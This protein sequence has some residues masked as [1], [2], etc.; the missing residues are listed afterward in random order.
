MKKMIFIHGA[1]GTG[2]VWQYQA[3]RFPGSDNVTL[4]GRPE[5]EP[6]DSID[7]YREWLRGYIA[8]KGYGPPVL[9]GQSMGGGIALSYALA[10]PDETA[11]LILIGSGA[12]LRVNPAFLKTM[13]DNIDKPPSWYRGLAMTMY[14][15]VEERVRESVLDATCSFPVSLHLNDFLCC[16][17][18]DVMERLPELKLPVLV[19]CGDK[20]IMT[21]LKYSRFMAEKITGSRLA[22]I[23]DAGHMA[24]LEKP[25]EVNREIADFMA[26][27]GEK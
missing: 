12:R 26:E 15:G 22:V 4:P 25:D 9:A 6:R 27:I 3:E 5:G 11:A 19:I 13:S 18:F 21:P 1:G 16:D 7:G 23:P 14:G 24:F 10:Y 17:R 2:A 8:D 20:D